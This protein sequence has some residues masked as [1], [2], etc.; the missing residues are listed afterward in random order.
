MRHR[1][2]L[3]FEGSPRSESSSSADRAC[4]LRRS[5]WRGDLESLKF[6]S[7]AMHQCLQLLFCVL[8]AHS[9]W[10]LP[11]TSAVL[12]IVVNLVNTPI[13]RFSSD[14]LGFLFEQKSHNRLV[15][16]TANEVGL[17]L[18]SA[19]FSSNSLATHGALFTRAHGSGVSPFLWTPSLLI[20]LGSAPLSN[21]SYLLEHS[22]WM[23]QN[24]VGSDPHC[25]SSFG[26]LPSQAEVWFIW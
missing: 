5:I 25:P 7:Q 6:I 20:G 26:L 1:E 22:L 23:L 10:G 17:W 3:T 16:T 14:C 18:R 9:S 19:P 4:L 8:E 13:G 2:C 24:G 12:E 15:I 11:A 21:N